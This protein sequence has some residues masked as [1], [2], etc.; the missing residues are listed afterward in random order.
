L[1]FNYKLILKYLVKKCEVLLCILLSLQLLR[2]LILFCWTESDPWGVADGYECE[3]IEN[4]APIPKQARHIPGP[5]PAQFYQTLEAVQT[6]RVEMQCTCCCHIWWVAVKWLKCCWQ[7]FQKTSSFSVESVSLFT[8][9]ILSL[10]FMVYFVNF[11]LCYF[12]FIIQKYFMFLR[13]FFY[14]ILLIKIFF[15][16]HYS[17][18]DRL[19]N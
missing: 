12:S 11:L 5:L 3:I 7:L 14:V 4:D 15:S 16:I 10:D 9:S 18:L 6:K 1:I 13:H 2:K 19:E 8:F 17:T